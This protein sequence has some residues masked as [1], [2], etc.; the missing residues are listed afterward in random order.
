M[1]ARGGTRR[2]GLQQRQECEQSS[3]TSAWEGWTRHAC[4]AR[5][6]LI[7]VSAMGL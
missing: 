6:A 1:H 3:N 2:F 5:R 7:H 4:R